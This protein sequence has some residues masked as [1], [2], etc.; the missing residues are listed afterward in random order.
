MPHVQRR[1][2][3]THYFNAD[4]RTM[5]TSSAA[6]QRRP[7]LQIL[8]CRYFGVVENGETKVDRLN[9]LNHFRRAVATALHSYAVHT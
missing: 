7:L 6:E 9:C 8:R 3:P 5:Q 1:A 4:F 2:A